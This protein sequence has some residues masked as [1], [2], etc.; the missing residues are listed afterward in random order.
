MPGKAAHPDPAELPSQEGF[1]WAYIRNTI[2]L[3]PLGNGCVALA[4]L[5][6]F[7]HGWLKR[8]YPGLFST[9][10]Y[11]IPL[12]VG[13]VVAWW[14]VPARRP[15]FPDSRTAIALKVVFGIC[16]VFLL[17]PTDVPW[18]IRFASFRGWTFAPL[19]FLV[20]YHL[21]KTPQQLRMA[22]WWI[23][24]L[25]VLVTIYG[26]RQSPADILSANV[27]DEGTMKTINGSTYTRAGGGAGFRVF[28]TFVGPGMF[29]AALAIGV[30]LSVAEI[31]EPTKKLTERLV[32]GMAGLLCLNGILISG[33]R[34]SVITTMIGSAAI[35]WFR[36]N[37]VKMLPAIAGL[38]VVGLGVSSYLGMTD[39]S[40]MAEVFSPEHLY[41][42]A[43]IVVG[44]AI[45][46]LLENPIGRGLGHA[47]HGVPVV[48]LH[49]VSRYKAAVIDGDLG[50]AA[51]DF[52]IVGMVAYIIMMIRAARDSAL[53]TRSVKGTRAETVA[54]MSSAMFATCL[55]SFITGS[56]FLHVPVGAVVW[57][58]IGGLNRIHDDRPREAVHRPGGHP[59]AMIA[60]GSPGPL[61]RGL[62]TKPVAGS[63][64]PPGLP[65][66]EPKQA[67]PKRF[68]YR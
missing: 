29:A 54:I 23:I 25:S 11:D 56:P 66:P 36:G 9:F 33:T 7:Y 47:T 58:F 62:V 1:N 12:M 32:W 26:M 48:M 52:G 65:R 43:Y 63:M 37:L 44:P 41:W 28:S 51:V 60:P 21:L 53:W 17:I 13:L 24:V 2:G 19:M 38:G 20:G 22:A 45:E 50:H 55:P 40:R 27:E 6:G 16:V 64:D 49:L 57:Y 46:M 68:L 5:I 14:S 67:K 30:I 42:R 34:S 15:L 8:K 61:Q 4:L 35:L 59:R 39:S 18:I 31:T 3:S 10:A